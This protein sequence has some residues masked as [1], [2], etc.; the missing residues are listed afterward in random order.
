MGGQGPSRRQGAQANRQGWGQR[1]R[2]SARGRGMLRA[3]WQGL[4]AGDHLPHEGARAH[5]YGVP[6]QFMPGMSS[7]V[8]CAGGC[9][10][11]A[12]CVCTRVHASCMLRAHR[13]AWPAAVALASA[14]T[15]W[16]STQVSTL[17]GK[18]VSLS[19]LSFP[20]ASALKVSLAFIVLLRN[21]KWSGSWS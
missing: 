9:L 20:P 18:P 15:H 14:C 6:F 5:G 12:T 21:V 7:T 16:P 10:L 19:V 17:D 13:A 11:C 4:L 8:V 1:S 2:L 3:G